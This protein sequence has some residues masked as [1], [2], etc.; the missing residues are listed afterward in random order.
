MS[1]ILGEYV[2]EEMIPVEFP[3]NQPSQDR[4]LSPSPTP[5]WMRTSYGKIIKGKTKAKKKKKET[6]KKALPAPC[7]GS[8]CVILGGTRRR[9]RRNRRR[10][11]KRRK[12]RKKRGGMRDPPDIRHSNGFPRNLPSNLETH[13]NRRPEGRQDG[14][15]IAWLYMNLHNI[16]EWLKELK[17]ECCPEGGGGNPSGTPNVNR[18]LGIIRERLDDIEE[19]AETHSESDDRVFSEQHGRIGNLE[20][21]LRSLRR[22]V[23]ILSRGEGRIAVPH[24][25]GRRRSRKRRGENPLCYSNQTR[26]MKNEADIKILRTRLNLIQKGGRRKKRG[27]RRKR[28][29]GNIISKF[30]MSGNKQSEQSDQ[31][32][33]PEDI[34]DPYTIM[35]TK[36]QYRVKCI[37]KFS[38]APNSPKAEMESIRS[39]EGDAKAIDFIV[40][41]CEENLSGGR[42]KTRKKRG[43]VKTYSKDFN[44]DDFEVGQKIDIRRKQSNYVKEF[45]WWEN[46]TVVRVGNSKLYWAVF[47]WDPLASTVRAQVAEDTYCPE[48]GGLHERVFQTDYNSIHSVRYHGMGK[49][50]KSARKTSGKR[51]KKKDEKK[52]IYLPLTLVGGKRRKTRNF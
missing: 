17:E 10:R 29:A 14:R 28:G 13:L 45:D 47:A 41:W 37:N 36:S 50:P 33:D 20:T 25:G 15:N 31:S 8:P 42:R 48:M 52:G 21:Q 35:R 23:N 22:Q 34:S 27:N 39:R 9:T 7:L 44:K 46:L 19:N 38:S 40:K 3:I 2:N 30:V 11:K 49:R 43:G 16:R 12:T 26:S 5:A 18:A 1:L 4:G 24:G 51:S 32:N 6:K